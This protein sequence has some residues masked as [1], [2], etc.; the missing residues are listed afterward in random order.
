MWIRLLG[1]IFVIS[2]GALGGCMVGR[3]L[4]ARQER[5]TDGKRAIELLQAEIRS[6]GLSLPEALLQVGR[7][8]ANAYGHAFCEIADNLL[9]YTG[10]PVSDIWARVVGDKLS[11]PCMKEQDMRQFIA[12]GEQLGLADCRLQETIL[13]RYVTYAE[14][15]LQQLNAEVTEKCRLYRNLGI[16]FGVFVTLVLL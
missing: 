9:E 13:Q 16:L 7:Y 10:E 8:A 2:A 1:A 15:E 5:L 4:R 3:Q 6:T 11:S 14:G 12:I